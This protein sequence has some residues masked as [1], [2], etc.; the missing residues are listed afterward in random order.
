MVY[1]YTTAD[2]SRLPGKSRPHL[3]EW[4]AEAAR[5]GEGKWVL[6]NFSPRPCT[7]RSNQP[8]IAS[9]TMVRVGGGSVCTDRF[10]SVTSGAVDAVFH[11]EIIF[12]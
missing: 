11:K 8:H 9:K 3:K 12:Y 2:S 10:D 7:G 6:D 5:A 4:K 1:V